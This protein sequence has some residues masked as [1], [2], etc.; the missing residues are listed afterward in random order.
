LSTR[1]LA[2][3][4]DALPLSPL[5]DDFNEDLRRFGVE[6]LRATIRVQLAAP[7]LLRFLAPAA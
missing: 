2:A 3:G 1:A 4:I 5:Q 6:M 7:D